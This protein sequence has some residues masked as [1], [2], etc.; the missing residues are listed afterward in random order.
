LAAAFGRLIISGGDAPPIFFIGV[1]GATS[2]AAASEH[3]NSHRPLTVGA[4]AP[5]CE[6][7]SVGFLRKIDTMSLFRH[8]WPDFDEI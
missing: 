3:Q 5:V 4:H 7:G 8:R 6:R 1:G 2:L